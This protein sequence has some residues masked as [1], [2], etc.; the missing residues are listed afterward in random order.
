[1][2]FSASDQLI[3]QISEDKSLILA[4]LSAPIQTADGK[5]ISIRP[6]LIKNQLYYQV[7]EQR[8]QQAV[9]RNLSFQDFFDLLKQMIRI[10]KQTTLYTNKGDYQI[11]IGKK[12]VTL[13]KKP[14][15]RA[16]GQLVHNR[17]KHYLIEEGEP[18]PFM[19]KLGLM[20][21]EGKIIPKKSDK[22]RQI[23][24]FLEMVND[25]VGSFNPA[26]LIRIIDFG[27]G[28]AYLSFA[29]FYFLTTLK[30]FKI[31]MVGLD[32]KNDL[33]EFCNQLAKDV[34]FAPDLKFVL[35]D[36][37]EYQLAQKVDLVVSLHAC[38]TATD[39]ALE[40][41]IG[42]DAKVILCVPCCQ[43]EL[44][45]QIN[46]PVLDPLLKHGILKER[47][48][49][50]ATDASRAQ[51]LEVSGYQ[52]QVL[53]FID[54]EHTPKNLLIRAIKGNK[55]SEASWKSYQEMRSFLHV[56]PSL[57]RRLINKIVHSKILKPH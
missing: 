18:I 45:H 14:P 31:E 27:C 22:F 47:F 3:N 53:E 4:I 54:M 43:H 57:E 50:L 36:I 49:A 21:P 55:E 25:V 9:H 51:L 44:Y 1:M 52:V 6:I 8:Q 19:I 10:Y 20:T 41:A 39:A 17:T 7:T 30:G 11:L 15:S 32:L 26:Q 12:K 16:P 29:L 28:K 40:K 42:W 48:A 33:V 38:D 56:N 13:L 24:R 2:D 23:N 34:G 5:K 35:G 37:N 46:C